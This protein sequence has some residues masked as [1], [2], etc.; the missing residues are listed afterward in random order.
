MDV[1]KIRANMPIPMR[2]FD[3]SFIFSSLLHTC[4]I[5]MIVVFAT[6]LYGRSKAVLRLH[7]GQRKSPAAE[8][9]RLCQPVKLT[10]RRR[11]RHLRWLLRSA[12]QLQP[13]LGTSA[14][15]PA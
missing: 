7:T 12:W 2:K 6:Q 8:A 4:S 1:P 13:H 5:A 15:A 14:V 9:A 10:W 3:R 11:N